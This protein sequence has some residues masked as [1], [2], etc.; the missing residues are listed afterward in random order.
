MF[1]D[2]WKQVKIGVKLRR[3]DDNT[4]WEVFEMIDFAHYKLK[5]VSDLPKGS[6]NVLTISKKSVGWSTVLNSYE[7]SYTI[8]RVVFADSEDKA[9]EIMKHCDEELCLED[10]E[11]ELTNKNE[12]K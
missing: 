12:V 2:E 4:I 11:F 6:P 8:K 3:I 5:A 7:F 9:K 10:C 1:N